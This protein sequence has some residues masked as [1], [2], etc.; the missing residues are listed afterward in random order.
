MEEM[1]DA[2]N[3]QHLQE[4]VQHLLHLEYL[5]EELMVVVLVQFFY[6]HYLNDN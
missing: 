5:L 6:V 4:Y 2:H 3:Q 1:N